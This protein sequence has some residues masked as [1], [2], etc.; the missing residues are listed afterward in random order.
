MYAADV[1]TREVVTI[2]ADAPIA[3]A[4][5]L[6]L[7]KRLSGL[8]VVDAAGRLVGI[9]T[10]GDF[11]RRAE[12]GTE[13]RH[14]RWLEYLLGP[15]PLAGEY[16]QAHTRKVADVMTERVSSVVEETPVEDIVRLMERRHIKRVPVIRDAAIVGIV[17][18]AD[19]LRALAALMTEPPSASVGDA[20]LRKRVLV[21]LAEQSWA[22]R[23][24]LQ[25]S[26]HGGVVQL[27][28]AILDERER[29]ALRV[30]IENVPGVERVDD[31]LC[32]VEPLSGFVI[33]APEQRS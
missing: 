3:K 7:E 19:L 2:E 25:V 13:M 26:V 24:G 8:P 16:V 20:A 23:V 4:V 9:V 28:G 11:L 14:P 21:A 17:S 6:M 27:S 1:M 30:A 31:Q 15:G 33:E 12:I 32:W 18:R 22:P 5:R 29:Q 10:E